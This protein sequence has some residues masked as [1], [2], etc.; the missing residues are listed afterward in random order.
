MSSVL[1]L[2]IPQD[3]SPIRSETIDTRDHYSS[4]CKVLN[5][6]AIYSQNLSTK[7]E[8]NYDTT[9]CMLA[10]NV[11]GIRPPNKH[12]PDRAGDL[13]VFATRLRDTYEYIE[14]D[15]ISYL[16]WDTGVKDEQMAID[17]IK[18]QLAKQSFQMN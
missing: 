17:L 7:L 4:L 18:A 6:T 15:F 12:I 11:A 16:D 2:V 3:G 8:S 10:Y 5:T 13:V 1:V 9:I 14:A